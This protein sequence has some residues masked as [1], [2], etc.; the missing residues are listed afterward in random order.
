MVST[1]EYK[2]ASVIYFPFPLCSLLCGSLELGNATGSIPNE[3]NVIFPFESFQLPESWHFPYKYHQEHVDTLVL[4]LKYWPESYYGLMLIKYNDI[5]CS[6]ALPLVNNLPLPCLIVQ[7]SCTIRNPSGN[8][9]ISGN[10]RLQFMFSLISSNSSLGFIASAL[11][12]CRSTIE[13]RILFCQIRESI[14]HSVVSPSIVIFI[15]ISDTCQRLNSSMP[16]T[17]DV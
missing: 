16:E 4:C 7:P 10:A 12:Q 6:H 13:S 17:G 2:R 5:N 8:L 11:Q 14:K 1:Q 3:T 15:P 9:L